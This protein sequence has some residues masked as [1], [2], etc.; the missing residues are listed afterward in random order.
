MVVATGDERDAHRRARKPKRRFQSAEPGA[1]D[2]H[3]MGF[4]RSR[5]LCR[6]MEAPLVLDFS[7][8]PMDVVVYTLRSK[9][10]LPMHRQRK[11]ILK[12]LLISRRE[13]HKAGYDTRAKDLC[14][15]LVNC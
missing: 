3:A 11:R 2:H 10:D 6:H 8:R 12:N 1:D 14:E 5:L 7:V 15:I 9:A 13:R 4:C